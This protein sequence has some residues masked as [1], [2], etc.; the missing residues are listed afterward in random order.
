MVETNSFF[1]WVSK[2]QETAF[3][4]VFGLWVLIAHCYPNC[5]NFLNKI[6]LH[7]YGSQKYEG[8]SVRTMLISSPAGSTTCQSPSHLVQPN[9][10]P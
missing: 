2:F 7:L 3:G 4:K 5:K 10:V 8:W 9:L 6:S 1:A